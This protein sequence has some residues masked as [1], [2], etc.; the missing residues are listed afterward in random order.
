MCI[1]TIV[2]SLPSLKA[3]VRSTSVNSSYPSTKGYKS[4]GPRKPTLRS[5]NQ[6]VSRT[7]IR[8]G[9]DEI[10]L[11]LEEWR[12]GSTTTTT[13]AVSVESQKAK[14]MEYDSAVVVRTDVTISRDSGIRFG[15]GV[16]DR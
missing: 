3:I 13:D 2:V 1:A 4:T 12:E 11:V 16:V 6:G 15:D 7:D 9:E 8:A 5:Q 14:G 10:G